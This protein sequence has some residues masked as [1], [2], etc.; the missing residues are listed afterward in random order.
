[1]LA[2]LKAD[3][4]LNLVSGT[5]KKKNEPPSIRPRPADRETPG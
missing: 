1:L 2:Y 5:A 3:K 4:R